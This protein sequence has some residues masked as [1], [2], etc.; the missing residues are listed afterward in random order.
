MEKEAMC[1]FGTKTDSENKNIALMPLQHGILYYDANEEDFLA[2]NIQN[3]ISLVGEYDVSF[4]KKAIEYIVLR[5]DA[6][7]IKIFNDDEFEPK[8]AID[9]HKTADIQEF[10]LSNMDEEK[11]MKEMERI[12]SKQKFN[13]GTDALIRFKIIAIDRNEYQMLWEYHHIMMDGKS[14]VI[15]VKDFQRFYDLLANGADDDEISKIIVEEKKQDVAYGEC[16]SMLERE[17]HVRNMQYWSELLEGYEGISEFRSTR[18]QVEKVPAS[19]AQ[20]GITLDSELCAWINDF[21]AAHGVSAETILTAAWGLTLQ[22]YNYSSDVVFGHT[23]SGRRCDIAGMD[24]TIGLFMNTVPIRVANSDETDINVFL[25]KIEKQV[26]EHALYSYCTLAEIQA[27]TPQKNNLIKVLFVYE[28]YRE[29]SVIGE[30]GRI[31]K[32]EYERQTA[33]YDVVV[34]VYPTGEVIKIDIFYNAQVYNTDDIE[35]ILNCVKQNVTEIVQKKALSIG[36]IDSV[37]KQEKNKVL[38]EFNPEYVDEPDDTTVVD[39]I[40]DNVKQYGNNIAL[41]FLDESMNYT[42]FNN[43][44]NQIARKLR[45]LGIKNND[46]VVVMAERGMEMVIGFYG[47]IKAGAA[48]VPVDPSYPQN[49]IRYIL[50]DAKPKAILT[51]GAD[52]NTDIPIIRLEDMDLWNEPVENVEQINCPD[53]LVY[54]IYTS[55]TTGQ[56]KGVMLC[57][58][59]LVKLAKLYK[60]LYHITEHD[61][62]LLWANCVFDMSVLEMTMGLLCG[63]KLVVT[64]KELIE[65]ISRFEEYTHQKQISIFTTTPKF[66]MQCDNLYT[67]RLLINGGEAVTRE[68]VEKIGEGCLYSN[69][70]GPTEATVTS[71]IWEYRKGEVIPRRIPIGRPLPYSKAYV[72]KGMQVCGIGMPGE[73]CIAGAGVSKGYLNKP[74]L[75]EQKFIDNPY[76]EGKLYRTGDL[77]RWLP[78]GNI[79]YLGRIDEQ[80]K[81]R[82]YRIELG[83]IESALRNIDTIEDAVVIAVDDEQGEKRIN[84]YVVSKVSLNAYEIKEKLQETLPQY[85]IPAFIVQIESIPMTRNGKVDK[86][87]LSAIEVINDLEI[88]EAP[89]NIKEEIL[90]QIF[91]EVLGTKNIGIKS[92]FFEYGGDSIKALRIVSKLRS[93]GYETSSKII[94]SKHKI[95]DIA[96]HIIKVNNEDTYEQGEVTGEVLKLPIVEDFEN[97]NLPKPNHFN[98]DVLIRIDCSDTEQIQKALKAIVIHHDMLRAV[99]CNSKIQILSSKESKLFDYKEFDLSGIVDPMVQIKL[100]CAKIEAEIDITQGPLM[101]NIFFITD[102]GN[103]LFMAI[104]HLVVDGVSLRV[105]V[106]DFNIC[107]KQL[108]EGKNVQLPMKTASYKE[109]T[110]AVE[111]YKKSKQ[112][113]REEKY[114]NRVETKSQEGLLMLPSYNKDGM[115]GQVTL[116]F[117]KMFTN[118]L[119][120]KTSKAFNTKIDDLMLSA[121]GMAI[122]KLTGQEVLTVCLE[123]HGREE[124]NRKINIDR[125]VGWFTTEYPVILECSA[126]IVS[127][128]ISVKDMKNRIPNHGFGYGLLRKKISKIQAD[129]SFNFLGQMDAEQSGEDV[130][131]LAGKRV[132]DENEG[133]IIDIAIT[134]IIS[135]GEL[136]FTF[137]YNTERFNREI[138]DKLIDSYKLCLTQMVEI[139]MNSEPVKTCTDYSAKDLSVR[140]LKAIKKK[141]ENEYTISDIYSLTPLQ[142]G[143]FFQNKNKLGSGEYFIQNVYELSGL[144][145]VDM[146]QDVL[147]LLSFKHNIL[148]SAIVSDGLECPRQVTFENRE[149]DYKKISIDAAD[150][151]QQNAILAQIKKDDIS[152]GFD[153]Q[154]DTMFRVKLVTLPNSRLYIIFSFHHIIVDGWCLGLII[155]D[156][157]KIYNYLQKGLDK[158]QIKLEIVKEKSESEDFAAYSKWIEKQDP[159]KAIDYWKELLEE[160]DNV[161]KIEPMRKPK[162]VNDEDEVEVE[163]V[164]FS[165]ILTSRLGKV[166]QK[167]HI[168]LNT[169]VEAALGIVLQRYNYTN[170]VVF[171]KVVSG[172]TADVKGIE[173]IVGIFINTLPV[174]VKSLKE[175]RVEDLLNEL[176]KQGMESETFSYSSLASVQSLTQQKANLIKVLYVYDNY[177]SEE[178]YSLGFKTIS[179]REQTNYDIS[180]TATVKGGCLKI[181]AM[182]DPKKYVK[183]EIRAFLK[184]IEIVLSS[185]AENQQQLVSDIDMMTEEDKELVLGQFNTNEKEYPDPNLETIVDLLEEQVK[186]NADRIAVTYN[187]ESVT[188]AQFNCKVNQIARKL[189]ALGVRPDDFVAIKLERG[190]HMLLGLYGIIKSGG[191]YVPL[192]PTYP[193]EREQYILSDCEPKAIVVYNQELDTDIPV[194]DLADESIFTESTENLNKVNKPDDLSYAIYT[195]GTTGRPKGVMI[196][197]KGVVALKYYLKELYKVTPEDNVIQFANY[198]FDAS[199]WEFTLSLLN[200]AKLTIA[201]KDIIS[202]VNTFNDFVAKEGIT[203]ALLPPQYFLKTNIS[204]FNVLTS[205]GSESSKVVVEKSLNHK[206]YINA[207]GPTETTVVVTH[208]EHDMQSEI[209]ELIPIGKRSPYAKLYVLNGMQLCGV[210]IPGELCIAGCTVARG[211]SKNPELTAEKF[212]DSPFGPEKMYRSG[213]LVKWLPD[214]NVAYLGRI[215]E[216]VKIRGFRI[217]LGEIEN[218]IRRIEGV[219][220]TAVIAVKDKNGDKEIYAYIVSELDIEQLDI[221]G[222]LRHSIPDY[223]VPTYIIQ[224]DSI[225]MTRSGKVERAALPKIDTQNMKNFVA[226]SNSTEAII[227]DI[228]KKVLDAN[229]I[230]VTDN[231]FE[232]GGHSLNAIELV[233]SM[234]AATGH[235]VTIKDVFANPTPRGL[236]ECLLLSNEYQSIPKAEIRYYYP[237]T[238]TQKRMYVVSQMDDAGIAYNVP[239]IMKIRGNVD[240]DRMRR[241]FEMLVERHEILRTDFHVVN[242]EL[243]QQV[244]DEVSVDYEYIEDINITIEDLMDSFVRRFNLASAPLIRMQLVKRDGYYLL[245][246]DM[247]HIVSDGMSLNLYIRELGEAYSGKTLK[248]VMCQYKDYSVWLQGRDL[249]KQRDYWKSEF[250]GDIPV[251]NL[252][253][254]YARPKM[255]SYEGA[256]I[257]QVIDSSLK[258]QISDMAKTTGTTDYMIFLSAAMILLSKYSRQEDIAIGTLV[259]G[260]TH[261]DVADTAG[262]FANTIVMRGKPTSDKNYKQFLSEIKN[263]CLQAYDNQEYPYEEL[264]DILDVKRDMARNPLFDVLLVL[265]NQNFEKINLDGAETEFIENV[266]PISKFDLKFDIAESGSTYRVQM[267]YC[268]ALFKP[269][270]I[271]NMLRQ[272]VNVLEQIIAN[273]DVHISDISTVSP[274]DKEK[275]FGEFNDTKMDFPRDLT[276]VDLFEN[277]VKNHPDRTALLFENEQIT[278]YQLNKKSNQIALALRENGVASNTRV[279]LIAERSIEMIA[280]IWGVL[281]AGG[282]YIPV[283]SRLPAERIQYI[284]DDS[285]PIALLVT[286]TNICS[287]DEE[288]PVIDLNSESLYQGDGLNLMSEISPKDLAYCIYTSGTSG[289]PKGVMIEHH[290]LMSNIVYSAQRFLDSDSSI[291]VPLFTNYS[292]DL[293]VPSLYLPVCYGGTLDLISPD[294]EYDFSYILHKNKYTFMKLTP[295]QLK[296]MISINEDIVLDSLKCIVVGG[297]LLECS[298]V[299]SFLKKFGQHVRFLNE[300]GPTEATVGSTLYH[301][302]GSNGR[303]YV[304]IGLPFANTQIYIMNGM[305]LCGVGV[306]GELCI[307]GEQLARGYMN[308]PELTSE[309]FIEHPL[310]KDRIYR[311][312]D[313]ARWLTDGNIECLGRIDEQVK[314]RGFRVELGEISNT[315]RNIEG[316]EDAIAVINNI[317]G[318]KTLCAYFVSGGAVSISHIRNVLTQKLPEYMIPYYMME[319]EKIPVTRNGKVDQKSLPEIMVKM[320]DNYVAPRSD[321][322]SKLCEAF[323]QIL[324]IEKVGIRDNFFEIGGDSIKGIRVVSKLREEGYELLLRNIMSRYTVESIAKTVSVSK[325]KCE[326]DQRELT[327]QIELTPILKDFIARDLPKPSHYNQSVFF[328]ID[329]SIEDKHILNALKAVVIH[330]D[331]LR[332]VLNNGSLEVLS[333]KESRLLDFNVVEVNSVDVERA[334]YEECT[335]LQES[336]HL[337]TGPLTKAALFRTK[338]KNYLFICI[339]HIVVDMVSWNIILDD[340][341]TAVDALVNRKR[342]ELTRKTASFAEWSVALNGYGTSTQL[343]K[344]IPYWTKVTENACTLQ[345]TIANSMDDSVG[346]YLINISEEETEKLIK[347]SGRRFNTEVQ[348]LL[349]SALAYATINIT[350]QQSIS[351]GLE[352]HGREQINKKIDIDR[353]VGWFTIK[354]PVNLPCSKSIRDQIID[355]KETLRQVPNK[356]LGYGLLKDRLPECNPDIYFNYLGQLKAEDIDTSAKYGNAIATENG[357]YGNI[358]IDGGIVGGHLQLAVRYR[359]NRFS[360]EIIEEFAKAYGDALNLI[361]QYCSASGIS[362]KTPSDY[363]ASN[364]TRKELKLLQDKYDD[365]IEDIY[366]LTPLQEGILYHTVREKESTAYVTQVIYRVQNADDSIIQKVLGLLAEKHDALRTAIVHDGLQQGRQVLIIGRE[367]EYEIFDF[368]ELESE[369]QGERVAQVLDENIRRGFELSKDTLMRVK[370]IKISE[371]ESKIVWCYHHIIFDGWC[372]T[373]LFN[374]FVECYNKL[375]AGQDIVVLRREIAEQKRSS[376]GTFCD[377]V[378][379]LEHQ[380]IDASMNY[381]RNLLDDYDEIADFR[382]TKKSDTSELQMYRISYDVSKDI[383][384]NAVNFAASNNITINTLVETA[385]G[386]L[387][388]KACY[389][390]DV[391]FGKVVSGRNA[392]IKGIENIVG[393]FINTIPVRIKSEEGLTVLQLLKNVQAQANE[394]ETY[395]YSSL[396]QIQSLTKQKNNLVKVLYTFENFF[397]KERDNNDGILK[398]EPEEGREQT[399]YSINMSASLINEQLTFDIIFDPNKYD[400]F[401][402]NLLLKRMEKII[403]SIISNPQCDVIELDLITDEERN[404]ILKDFNDTAL[405]YP[406]QYT[407]VDLLEKQSEE[408]ADRIAVAYKD[409][410][411]TYRE[412][413]CKINQVAHRLRE[414]GVGRND[415]VGIMSQRGIEMII[416]VYAVIKAGGA[417]IPIDPTYPNERIQY[418]ISNS[419]AKA[420]L[421]YKAEVKA[422]CQVIDLEDDSLY[423]GNSYNPEKVNTPD[424]VA[425]AIYTSG[426]TG[427]PKGVMIRHGGVVAFRYYLRELYKVV[428]D[429]I[430]LQFANFVFDASV[431]EMTLSI[432]NGAKLT[433]VS[434]ETI[435]DMELFDKFVRDEGI[436]LTLLPPQYYLQSNVRNLR[437]M[438]TGGDASSNLIVEKATQNGGY[439]NAYGPTENTVV[440]TSWI[441]NGKNDFVSTVPIGKPINNTQIYIMNGNNLCG[442]GVPGEL[443]IAGSSVAAG[444]LNM[445]E[446]TNDKFVDNLFGEGMLYRSGD[447]AR[448]LYDGNIEYLGRIDKQVK[449]RGFRIELDEVENAIRGI[450]NIVDTTVIDV[451]DLAGDK[452]LCAYLVS[453]QSI[454]IAEVR[455]MLKTILPEY[456]VPSLMMQVDKIPVTRS[457]KIDRDRLPQIATVTTGEYVQPCDEKERTICGVFSEFL[458]VNRVGLSDNFYE[459]GGDSIKALRIVSALRSKGYDVSVKNIMGSHSME[460]IIYLCAAINDK[461]QYE[462]G[463]VTGVIVPTPIMNEFNSWNLR[464][465]D[466]FNQDMMIPVKTDDDEKIQKALEA[467]AV[468]HDILRAVYRNNTLEILGINESKLYDYASF[469]LIESDE[470]TGRI[471]KECNKIQESIS[472]ENGPLMKAALFKTRN[473]CYLFICIHHLIVDTVSWKILVE[474]FNTALNQISDGLEISLPEKTASFKEWS[475]ALLDYQNST[476]LMKVKDYWA[477][478]AITLADGRFKSDM[479]SGLFK[480]ENYEIE[481]NLDQTQELTQKSCNAYNTTV[482]DLLI[483]AIGYAI[484]KLTG[485]TSVGVYLEGHGREEIHKKIDIDRTVGWFTTVYPI[486]INCNY[487]IENLIVETKE[488]IRNIPNHGF[489]YGL[490]KH[491]LPNML[492]DIYFNYMGEIDAEADGKIIFHA[493]GRTSSEENDLKRNINISGGISNGVLKFSFTHSNVFSGESVKLFAETYKECLL[494]IIQFC[495]NRGELVKTISDVIASDLETSDLDVIN[496]LFS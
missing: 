400:E 56:P 481:L 257:E 317:A 292:F 487:D 379:W 404:I 307:A 381:W 85:M 495:M 494:E 363:S 371:N 73:L 213:D 312:G 346:E 310:C 403:S 21:C 78:D 1:Y 152:A 318:D 177:S 59:N 29:L 71:T 325:E 246:L 41:E 393:L 28:D 289:K 237:M 158:S 441:Y 463:E 118:D 300:Y 281:K 61:N 130:I 103:Y 286:D 418:I 25:N 443:C 86:R 341:N 229:I 178:E 433:I 452:S 462:Q 485:Q 191:A 39:L 15:L 154:K 406:R 180:V 198:V 98:Q 304:P 161:A 181:G 269:E 88:Y 90:C 124:I 74:E 369:I 353:T 223:M 301:Y 43:K 201:S 339:H 382:P 32:I 4:I 144:D 209:P 163:E 106:E 145:K 259:S 358:D 112:L 228:F 319:I 489:D 450:D 242:D 226:P 270:S 372:S 254:D 50:E 423:K 455:R 192:D 328:E 484:H 348:D 60:D 127:N 182:Y 323:E 457:G 49:R 370:Y 448:W 460:D 461:I 291:L 451:M 465:P 424:D 69:N 251:L 468:H 194:L 414:I 107:L 279:M 431:W 52:I 479:H 347:A 278:Y 442:I 408:C 260:R 492:I 240:T 16:V 8:Q 57:H 193:A 220:D 342:V 199:V 7:K 349:L 171:G 114:W 168:T 81:I 235:N 324:G 105:I 290:S 335:A 87:K 396:A 390:N 436:T 376:M 488:M 34:N 322:E 10:D 422:E 474:D 36:D 67:P 265:Q 305:E 141:Y 250:S 411:I 357:I 150:E 224:I 63:A 490:L 243:V 153:F 183:K 62:V 415:Y 64:P 27:M 407:V 211:Y 117:N 9:T 221:K 217:E 37:P 258:K 210:G 247:H 365:R 331:M 102:Q 19:K 274:E 170:D 97:W 282:A 255:Q 215:D 405:D 261:K 486:K 238:S 151:R 434:K 356:G 82:G 185:L 345:K 166:T 344:E 350:D 101:K 432:L 128:I 449:I 95:I 68:I 389:V 147:S 336:I 303:T 139:C 273:S 276:V 386:I 77:V 46:S 391:V 425:Y 31:L 197:H 295:S 83:E 169:F 125:T 129:I 397:I 70:Y 122:N 72:L 427:E 264:V 475:E 231:F 409:D 233:N 179:E 58:R 326:Y 321:I 108:A 355:V 22:K 172:R 364:L 359:R 195:S 146:I 13:M 136:Q 327:G 176:Q 473:G 109:W 313:L 366:N 280:A 157:N 395:S 252:P 173:K 410:Q 333:S 467:L 131:Y 165:D 5:H 413:N 142:S 308:Q 175:T 174:R 253:L 454:D 266:V 470:I 55:G 133:S 262:M 104:H 285:N 275:I 66:F 466:H 297:E 14:F 216:Q 189:R 401:D 428:V 316:I 377:Y 387:L 234:I 249:T 337:S 121:I 329:N 288:R 113:L 309:K 320:T 33:E 385:W 205:A 464:K 24:R 94:V 311:T 444:Y 206:R 315:I 445:P 398:F 330:H 38:F 458:G 110:N 79:D 332:A 394:S 239:V 267:E 11:R 362:E 47:I 135:Q 426:T 392:D 156:F 143:I 40:E 352:G 190:I 298:L 306:P 92:D 140:D 277:Q 419:K 299:D 351:V 18:N 48:Y 491:K 45:A 343:Q 187:G 116:T 496:S 115:E 476:V 225:P 271:Q 186:E 435:Q 188:Y 360:S 89:R 293:T 412:L 294:K 204:G 160:Y 159:D 53:D 493:T 453:P 437:I 137:K 184:R 483:C 440:A 477:E 480:T 200:G 222:Q 196:Q 12:S 456:M 23:V 399:D 241:A 287:W 374:D 84:A 80:V 236:A 244:H 417:Y 2:Y 361:V 402:I 380:D 91:E 218:A 375:A 30:D 120:R 75:T 148:T 219:Y 447:L 314:I 119:V 123:G 268:T 354:Y 248:P 162:D 272:Y 420:I 478:L 6:L 429:D 20:V 482:N 100:E 334:I 207:Y 383:C 3:K 368:S 438:T 446:L 416:G 338:N 51:F 367:I 388:Q 430:V 149:I 459:L 35:R 284:I 212:I 296:L 42:E 263:T 302:K 214:G 99:Y 230:S 245:M 76:G 155:D 138:I 26:E 164:Q 44:L 17:D 340:F 96:P 283:D 472:I 203:Q 111:E 126:D 134:G 132:A 208:W 378:T 232:I 421:I 54:I 471:E 439:V 256:I 373:M 93:S 202:D 167:M 227:C 384:R 65:D 469:D